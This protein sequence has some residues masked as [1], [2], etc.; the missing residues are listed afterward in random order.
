VQWHTA[1]TVTRFSAFVISSYSVSEEG[2]VYSSLQYTGTEAMVYS[3]NLTNG[4]SH[5]HSTI[6]ITSIQK[7]QFAFMKA[8]SV[9]ALRIS[10]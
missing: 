3:I 9:T 1:L 7:L 6:L 10:V 5:T 2:H 4:W 8:T